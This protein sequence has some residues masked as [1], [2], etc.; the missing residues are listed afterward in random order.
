MEYRSIIQMC[1]INV[2]EAQ[3]K[4][5][6]KENFQEKIPKKKKI[7]GNQKFFLF[8]NNMGISADFAQVFQ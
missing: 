4:S 8:F 2:N 3:R 7:N 1:L 6:R 5:T